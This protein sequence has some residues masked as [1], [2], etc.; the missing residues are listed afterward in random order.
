M[1]EDEEESGEWNEDVMQNIRRREEEG[2]EG[3]ERRHLEVRCICLVTQFHQRP[4]LPKQEIRANPV[5]I[6]YPQQTLRV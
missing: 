6:S 4:R 2:D 3:G 1:W 5:H